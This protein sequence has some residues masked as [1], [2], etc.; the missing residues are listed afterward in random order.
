[1]PLPPPVAREPIHNRTVVCH[2]YRRADGLWDIEGRITDIKAYPFANAYRG[3]IEPGDPL[4][5]MTIRLTLDDDLNV[6]DVA[7]SSDRTPYALCPAIAPAF[8]KLIGLRIG[9]GWRRALRDRVGGVHGCTHMVELLGPIATTAFQ[10]IAPLRKRGLEPEPDKPPAILNTC[11]ALASDS[12]IVR[13][14][15]P[16]WYTGEDQG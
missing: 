4:H 16:R 1:M 13:L 6:I 12:E 8:R 2:G 9:P 7:A 15:W 5:D 14:E 3:T 10:T 11:H